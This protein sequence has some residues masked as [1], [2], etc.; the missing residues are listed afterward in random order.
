MVSHLRRA[1]NN[2]R[3]AALLMMAFV[4]FVLLGAAAMTVDFGWLFWQSLEIQHAAD[5]SALAGVV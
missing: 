1:S 3:G 4:L 5:A 2:E